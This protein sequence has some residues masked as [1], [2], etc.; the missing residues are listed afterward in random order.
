M[1]TSADLLVQNPGNH[2]YKSQNYFVKDDW[3]TLPL[4]SVRPWA[5]VYSTFLTVV[6]SLLARSRAPEVHTQG[7]RY[8][9]WTRLSSSAPQ[10]ARLFHP[11]YPWG[12]DSPITATRVALTNFPGFVHWHKIRIRLLRDR[13][14]ALTRGFPNS[15]SSLSILSRIRSL[16][17][18]TSG[19][20]WSPLSPFA[21][22]PSLPVTGLGNLVLQY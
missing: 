18:S 10:S 2:L 11:A 14:T 6:F 3:D 17:I 9:R 7:I 4:L 5:L 21:S 13:N 12:L 8:L 22:L 20:S 15:L 19:L 1:A 16:Q